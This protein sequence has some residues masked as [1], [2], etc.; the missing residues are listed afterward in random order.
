M[1]ILKNQN[2]E[3]VVMDLR[4]NNNLEELHDNKINLLVNGNEVI[5]CDEENTYNDEYKPITVKIQ[6]CGFKLYRYKNELTGSIDIIA[7]T[8]GDMG[9]SSKVKFFKKGI[10][11]KAELEPVI[12]YFAVVT[13]ESKCSDIIQMNN[14]LYPV[15]FI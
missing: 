3:W 12:E 11:L 15:A 2:E 4:G 7:K 1:K 13:D 8:H 10:S 14:S 5:V 6:P 9:W